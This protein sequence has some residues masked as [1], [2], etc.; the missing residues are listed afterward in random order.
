MGF[1][2]AATDGPARACVSRR[3]VHSA[4]RGFWALFVLACASSCGGTTPR[5]E[6]MVFVDADPEVSALTTGL[7]FQLHGYK[8]GAESAESAE[9]DA[10]FEKL[11]DISAIPSYSDRNAAAGKTYR[12]LVTALDQAGNESPRSAPVTV[13]MP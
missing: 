4:Q 8:P 1:S 12:Y 13:I 9:G 7:R 6:V 5:T 3:R 2:M 10:P 11:A